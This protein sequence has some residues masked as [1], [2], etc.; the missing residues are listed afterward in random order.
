MDLIEIDQKL[1]VAINSLAN[2][3]TLLD[4]IVKTMVNEYFITTALSLILFSL[5]FWGKVDRDL[6][7]KSVLLGV[8][9]VIIGSIGV[10]SLVNFLVQRPRPFDLMPV[11]L[12]FYKPTDPSFPSNSAVVAF[13]LAY[14][15]YLGDK[16]LGLV[17]L[18]LAGLYGFFR[19]YVGVHFPSDILAGAF[20]GIA[21]VA[22]LNLKFFDR[23]HEKILNVLRNIFKS[24]RLEEF[25]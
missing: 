23:L 21:S 20:I 15:I 1:F 18:M 10:V 13:A 4:Q 14:A 19:I 25:S 16:R 2:K 11:N 3:N 7:Q 22:V 5:W 12:L 6:K 24:L 17:A 8:F 9:G